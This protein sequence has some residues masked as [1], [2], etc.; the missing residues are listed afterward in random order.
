MGGW[1]GSQGAQKLPRPGSRKR[2]EW[3]GAL[4]WALNEYEDNETLRGFA[5]MGI[6]KKVVGMALTGDHAAIAEI[7]NRL[8]GKPGEALHLTRD[9]QRTVQDMTDEEL[10]AILVSRRGGTADAQEGEDESARVHALY[11]A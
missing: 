7:G 8:D 3:L 11:D 1:R 6:A 5:L 9:D 2:G 10:L 4:R